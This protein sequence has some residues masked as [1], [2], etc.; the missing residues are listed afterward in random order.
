MWPQQ[1]LFTFCPQNRFVPYTDVRTDNSVL[2]NGGMGAARLLVTL[3]C[4]VTWLYTGTSQSITAEQFRLLVESRVRALA[5]ISDNAYTDITGEW[6]W[7]TIQHVIIT[8]QRRDI[9]RAPMETSYMIHVMRR[10]DRLTSHILT[11]LWRRCRC[12]P[13]AYTSEDS[14]LA[15]HNSLQWLMII[16]NWRLGSHMIQ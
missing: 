13:V 10:S 5:L 9:S 2:L 12:L 16:S 3:Y 1:F 15:M 6:A 7:F 8:L 11:G 14:W 4:C